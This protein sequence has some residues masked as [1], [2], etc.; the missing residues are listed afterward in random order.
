[1]RNTGAGGTKPSGPSAHAGA[2]ADDGE[3]TVFQWPPPPHGQ[4]AGAGPR[5]PML[6]LR[7]SDRPDLAEPAPVPRRGRRG[8]A[9][10]PGRVP[11]P[12]GQLPSGPPLLQPLA[13][14]Q[15]G[16][17]RACRAVHGVRDGRRMHPSSMVRNGT[18]GDER[19]KAKRIHRAASSSRHIDRMVTCSMRSQAVRRRAE[20]AFRCISGM[21]RVCVFSRFRQHP[22][23]SFVPGRPALARH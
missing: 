19:S 8:G 22:G 15:A 18:Q 3:P 21:C 12:G 5:R 23:G 11:I 14:H 7:P 10:I 6:D 9:G 13:R 16:A 20:G 17:G 1:M 2:V 4:G